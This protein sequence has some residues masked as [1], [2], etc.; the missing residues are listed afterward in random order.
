MPEERVQLLN[1]SKSGA[2][3][4]GKAQL[5]FLMNIQQAWEQFLLQM[6]KNSEG[7]K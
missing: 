1:T 5:G 7:K 6:Y 3:G 4:G 2:G